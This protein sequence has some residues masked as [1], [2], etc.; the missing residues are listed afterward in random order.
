MKRCVVAAVAA[1]LCPLAEAVL[2][3]RNLSYKVKEGEPF[4]LLYE[5]C[6]QDPC[7]IYLERMISDTGSETLQTITDHASHGKN[8]NI[9]FILQGIPAG[10]YYFTI[11]DM[12]GALVNSPGF[13]Y[14]SSADPDKSIPPSALLYT[15]TP[16]PSTSTRTT[17]AEPTTTSQSEDATMSMSTS[18]AQSTQPPSP[19]TPGPVATTATPTATGSPEPQTSRHLSSGSLAGIIVGCVAAFLFTPI[20]AFL[21]WRRRRGLKHGGSDD[22]DPDSKQPQLQPRGASPTSSARNKE[23][24]SQPVAELCGQTCYELPSDSSWEHKHHKLTPGSLSSAMVDSP[25]ISFSSLGT[26]G[27]CISE[28]SRGSGTGSLGPM[29]SGP[30]PASMNA[31][32]ASMDSPTIPEFHIPSFAESFG[33]TMFSVS[34]MGEGDTAPASRYTAQSRGYSSITRL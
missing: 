8:S 2:G 25:T 30:S 26:S 9:T 12:L 23:L 13:Y 6:N 19:V 28:A 31:T 1:S 27:L 7:G 33:A 14:K 34:T 5:G 17:T 20:A 11:G 10:Q 16:P 15:G 32:L 4:T 21:W 29:P 18:S 24:D 3:F 22:S